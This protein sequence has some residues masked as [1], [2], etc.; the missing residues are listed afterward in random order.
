MQ[1]HLSL[2]DV[3]VMHIPELLIAAGVSLVLA[4]L[5]WQG[6]RKVP[7]LPSPLNLLPP[8]VQAIRQATDLRSTLQTTLEKICQAT[9]WEYGESWVLGEDG[10]NLECGSAWYGNSSFEEFRKASQELRFSPD[11]GIAGKVWTSRKP[12]WFQQVAKQSSVVFSRTQMAKAGFQIA[13]GIPIIADGQVVAVLVFFSRISRSY[14]LRIIGLAFMAAA[15]AGSVIERNL[16]KNILQKSDEEIE[17][18]FQERSEG[19]IKEKEALACEIIS[20]RKIEQHLQKIQKNDQ[21]L[22]HSIGGIV[23]EYDL[24]TSK[25]TFV[26]DQAES[27]LGYPVETWLAEPNFWQDHIHGGDRELAVAFRERAAEEK[28]DDQFEYRM[29]TA[30]GHARWFRDMV[31]VVIEN[32]QAVKLRGTMVDIT[33]QKLVEEALSQERNY[34][35]AVLDMAGALVIVLDPEGK[36]VRFNSTAEKISGRSNVKGSYFWDL[37]CSPKDISKMKTIM[38]RLLAGQFPINYESE[39]TAK[40]GNQFVTAWSHTVLFN[41][42]NVPI[43]IIATGT[44][45]TKRKEIERRLTEVIEELA[46]SNQDLDRYSRELKDANERL[47]RLDEMKSEFFSA[48]SHELKTPLTSIE[49]YLETIL[50]EEVGPLN[51]QQKDFLGYVKQSTDRLHR[52]LIELLD[53]SKIESGQIKM[54]K[55]W[56]NLRE[57]L[58]E[59]LMIFKAQAGA[60]DISLE[61]E[62][63]GD[64]REIYCDADKIREVMDNLISNAIKYTPRGGR[65]KIK[66]SNLEQGVRIDV[67]DTGIGIKEQDFARI[68]EPFQCIEKN[69]TEAEESVGLGLTLVKKIVE[70]HEGQIKVA[71]LEAKGSTFSVIFP[72]GTSQPA[73]G[74]LRGASP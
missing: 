66:S 3:S 17:K 8:M 23:W 74:I 10:K 59:E 37:F 54:D 24:L 45:I 31:R 26:S 55:D 60:K 58:K 69:G 51:S 13:L 57:L 25:F 44:D 36:I 5:F 41:K 33:E 71:S 14:D 61:L 22:I 47:K 19:L 62:T 49:G 72:V 63:G 18:N 67:Q 6:R 32:D 50:Q 28:T 64:L 21:A 7:D 4:F 11:T 2:Y 39:W 1:A 34:T 16:A 46:R 42:E 48:A 15:Q 30:D 52:L 12:E 43:N 27:M 56:T 29:I 53:I 38:S 9:G 68:F 35:T 20:L 40:D 70:A 73:C 65:V